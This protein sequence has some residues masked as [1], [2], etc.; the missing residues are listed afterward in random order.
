MSLPTLDKN[1]VLVWTID[2]DRS[3]AEVVRCQ[4]FLTPSEISR[5]NRFLDLQQKQRFIVA[6]TTLRKILSYYFGNDV[7][8]LDLHY[9][10]AGKPYLNHKSGLNFNLSYSQNMAMIAL[11]THREVGIDIE[12]IELVNNPDSIAE[13]VCSPSEIAHLT[14]STISEKQMIFTKVWVR[15]E[16]YIKALG[17]GFSR[18]TQT[19]SVSSAPE[20]LDALCED[21]NNPL[22]AEQWRVMD[23]R[24]PDGYCAAL[25]AQGRDWHLIE[26]ESELQSIDLV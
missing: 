20:T 2:L 18:S 21:Q 14:S 22:A 25:A 7:A 5:A 12:A 15:K 26:I 6:R 8:L 1:Q 13:L 19:F 9:G 3:P 11:S 4:H 16:A 17:T 24:A 23:I 10:P